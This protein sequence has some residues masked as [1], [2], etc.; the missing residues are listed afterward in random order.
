[1]IRSGNG[2]NNSYEITKSNFNIISVSRDGKCQIK[3]LGPKALDSLTN[4]I[5]NETFGIVILT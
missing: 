3:I 1:M 2:T 4:I 5:S